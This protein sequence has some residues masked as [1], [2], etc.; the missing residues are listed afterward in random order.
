MVLETTTKSFN[1]IDLTRF[2][3]LE[4]LSDVLSTWKHEIQNECNRQMLQEC[5]ELRAIHKEFEK[6]TLNTLETKASKADLKSHFDFAADLVS[7]A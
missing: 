3:Q 1:E 6:K 5:N 7:D 2:V 4:R